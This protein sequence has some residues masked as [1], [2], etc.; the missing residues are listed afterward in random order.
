MSRHHI[1]FSAQTTRVGVFDNAYAPVLA[2]DDG[3]EVELRVGM[4]FGDAI[5]PETTLDELVYLHT[6]KYRGVGSHTLTG[7]IEVRQARAGQVL[8]VSILELVPGPHGFNFTFPAD[9]EELGPLADVFPHGG[10]RHFKHDPD[11][12]T[13][14]FGP[15]IRTPLRP[16]LGILGVAPSRPG[17]HNS[18]RPG[19]HGGNLDLAELVAGACIYLPVLVDGPCSVPGTRTQRKDTER[20]APAQSR[21]RWSARC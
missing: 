5:T 11:T 3:D 17:P 13:T 19:A 18:I 8:K 15:G 20:S 9:I 16:F 6:I 1:D 7:P 10:I 12:M 4:L 21:R 14:E 2:I